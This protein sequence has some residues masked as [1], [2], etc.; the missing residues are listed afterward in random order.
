MNRQ[1]AQEPA[2][3]SGWLTN[4]QKPNTWRHTLQSYTSHNRQDESR[5]PAQEVLPQ[6]ANVTVLR[7][8]RDTPQSGER[9][10]FRVLYKALVCC[11]AAQWPQSTRA[12]APLPSLCS[13]L[14]SYSIKTV[15]VSLATCL[16]QWRE[17]WP[18]HG[19]S[20][21][22]WRGK[23]RVS[24]IEGDGKLADTLGKKGERRNGLQCL[25]RTDTEVKMR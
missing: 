12:F 11:W 23:A 16:Q 25:S 19:R 7:L 1:V 10:V 20:T 5:W 9:G 3:S 15:L 4:V 22:P 14:P 2:P 8:Q 13:S 21:V 6:T 24:E 18:Q 17:L